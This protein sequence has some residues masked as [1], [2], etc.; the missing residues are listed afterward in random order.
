M[1]RARSHALAVCIFRIG[2][3]K[4][5]LTGFYFSYILSKIFMGEKIHIRDRNNP[6]NQNKPM[7]E[8]GWTAG[9][10]VK[11]ILA[12][13]FGGIVGG[14]VYI[15]MTNNLLKQKNRLVGDHNNK[16]QKPVNNGNS[17]VGKDTVNRK[18]KEETQS[19]C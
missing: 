8:R 19:V 9:K 5:L 7:E 13:L 14:I 17:G 10:V 2:A 11:A 15:V 3:I 18:K 1:L 16:I 4:T 6:E 12:S